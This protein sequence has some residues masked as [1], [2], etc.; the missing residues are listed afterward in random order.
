MRGRTSEISVCV[1]A[2][3]L[4][5]VN[6]KFIRVMMD[7]VSRN[8]SRLFEP[9]ALQQRKREKAR[10]SRVAANHLFHRATVINFIIA[11]S[12]PAANG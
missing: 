3:H 4:I 10:K 8:D 7:A 2:R 6:R 11:R 5:R 9:L 1:S 12:S